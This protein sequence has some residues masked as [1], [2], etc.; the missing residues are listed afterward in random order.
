MPSEIKLNE[1]RVGLVPSSVRE[2]TAKSHN[3]FIESG[4]GSGIVASDEEYVESGAEIL[5]TAEAEFQNA[6]MIVK[7]KEPQPTEWL[8]L[9]LTR[10]CLHTFILQQMQIRLLGSWRL[11]AVRS[12]MKP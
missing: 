1:H 7:V 5:N 12:P 10:S 4:A 8:V 11:V 9:S 2:L 3:V 6:Q